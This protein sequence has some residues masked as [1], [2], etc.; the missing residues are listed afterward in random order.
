[1]RIGFAPAKVLAEVI[2]LGDDVGK[3][4][5]ARS[6]D[7]ADRLVL[8]PIDEL[9]ETLGHRGRRPAPRSMRFNEL[10]VG[11]IVRAEVGIGDAL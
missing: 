1:M 3:S 4:S 2:D 5:R 8:A 10:Q 11:Q 7:G 6:I 9:A